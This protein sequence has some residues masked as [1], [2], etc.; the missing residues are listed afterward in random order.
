MTAEQQLERSVLESKEREELH[1]IAQA[2]SV[3]TNTRTKKADIIDGILRATGV[4]VGDAPVAA[5]ATRTPRPGRNRAAP[6]VPDGIPAASNGD[7]SDPEGSPKPA[8]RKAAV[9]SFGP[10][11]SATTTDVSSELDYDFD[12]IPGAGK[13]SAEGSG[14]AATSTDPGQNNQNNQNNQGRQ[15]N[16]NNQG[17]NNQ[18]Q[19]NQG[20]GGR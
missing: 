2:L 18:G 5:P 20:Q 11:D 6:D 15:N 8:R 19:N 13:P 17:Q 3:K 10:S 7:H 1:A 4:P 14:D 9:Q 16:Q 12:D